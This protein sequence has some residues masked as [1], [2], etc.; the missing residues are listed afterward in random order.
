M[1]SFGEVIQTI[2]KE[3]KTLIRYKESISRKIINAQLAITFNE[4]CIRERLLPKYTLNIP[5]DGAVNTSRRR[6][7]SPN[8]EER[9]SFMKQ[10]IRELQL[11]IEE[12][13]PQLKEQDEKWQKADI[14]VSVK[15]TINTKLK[16]AL[17]KHRHSIARANQNKLVRLNGGSIKHA[18]PIDPY[19]N[20]TDKALTQD[21]QEILNMGLNCHVLSRPSKFN[22]RVECEVLIDNVEKL[23]KS[24][25]VTVSPTFKQEVVTESAKSR[26]HYNSNIL[27]KRHIDAA[28]ELRSDRDITIRRADKAAAYVLINTDEYLSK[29]GSILSDTTKFKKISRNPTV[30]L[31]KKLNKIIVKNNSIS[32]V[33]FE[34]LTGE[35]G[36]GY[37]Y[38]NV[39]THKPGNKLRPII[40]QIPT[41][42]YNIAKRL[43][44][45][46][47]PYI[48]ATYC[49]Q[50][51]TD[52]IDILNNN[53]ARG[54]I[55]S[56]DVESL[57]TN[58]PVDRTINYI[59]NRVYYND[60][61]PTLGIQ[62]DI[63]RELLE[64]CTKEAPFTC[65]RGNKYCQVDGVAMGS[66]L[67]VL[68]ANFFMGCIEEEV[69]K[70]I[71]KPNIYCR[72]IDDIFIKTKNAAEAEH[73]R[74]HLQEASGLNFT[75][76]NSQDGTMPFLDVLVQQ[77]DGKFS[78]TV[79]N[80][81]TNPGL[82]LN[83]RS[84]C[85]TR[86]KDSTISAYIR[87]AL[88]HCST[89][90]QVHL[91]IERSTQVL[92]NNGFCEKDINRLT[93]KILDSWLSKKQIEENKENINIFY[94]GTFSSA[95]KEDERIITQ[96]VRKNIKPSDPDK[97][98][99]LI[100]YY[101]TKKT[102]H[103]LLK[104]NPSIERESLQKSH[105]IYRFTCNQGNCEV[106]PSTYVGMT[107][108]RLSQRLTFHL[109]SGAPKKHLKDQHRINITREMLTDNT[110][111]LT[112]CPDT[113]RLSILEALYT[114]AANPALNQ[115]AQDLQALP[116]AR[117]T[118]TENSPAQPVTAV[119]QSETDTRTGQASRAV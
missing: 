97:R 115:Q 18:R 100:I 29:M 90:K 71:E 77:Q 105:V 88:T 72:Y 21:Q 33:K 103:L 70:K 5:C 23:Q 54:T 50:S 40:S 31:K 106:L 89:W 94:K 109:A 82:C 74:V 19:I 76:E 10:R 107:T 9:T 112:T 62:E 66:P 92:L 104:N 27:S 118:S 81:P 15:E 73:L 30:A 99:K 44:V 48:P 93:K 22:K 12:L 108:T 16:E 52:F 1:T 8:N 4:I 78:T 17:D 58:V 67:G 56:L 2:K 55:A 35:Y 28:K 85:P 60:S 3:N 61:T 95:Y 116:S 86:Y 113:R 63:L 84:E 68:L 79:Y 119:S 24:G 43:C 45:L 6:R 110:E 47:T 59:I 83:G 69:F 102:S 39:K 80:K 65:P 75:I 41:P 38:G 98:V 36:M 11:K 51:A 34:R 111:I 114:K 7:R 14:D 91:E 96:L 53:D 37:C 101:K 87:R 25:Q 42:T 46:L 13:E 26:G 20:L 32:D 64:S 49:L 117:R 57:F